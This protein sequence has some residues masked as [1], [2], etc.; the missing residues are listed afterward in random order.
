ML[1][2]VLNLYWMSEWYKD[3]N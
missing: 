2:P 3:I 1:T